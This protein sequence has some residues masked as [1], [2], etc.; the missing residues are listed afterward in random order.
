MLFLRYKKIGVAFC[1][2]TILGS[3]VAALVVSGE[4]H[5]TFAI[6]PLAHNN[7]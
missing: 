1:I 7:V 4:Q 5:V 6:S 3:I 2:A